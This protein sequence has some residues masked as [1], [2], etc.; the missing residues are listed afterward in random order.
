VSKRLSLVVLVAALLVVALAGGVLVALRSEL[1]GRRTG[2]PLACHGCGRSAT[3]A[4]ARVGEPVS[5]G[6]LTLRNESDATVTLERVALLDVDPGLE[7]IDNVVVQPDGRH[8][9]V[10]GVHGYPP[11]EP[12][13]TT[14]A[15]R[16]YKL[17]PA[18]SRADVVQVLFGLR[19][20]RPARAGARRIAVDYR[21]GRV[22]YRAYFDHSMWLCTWR[23]SEEG[24]CIDPDW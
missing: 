14:H 9:L 20:T 4:P 10:G 1:S 16:G 6:P 3:A 23:I 15:V 17:E 11:P 13:G 22:P 2:G 21:V 12:G 19:L 24:A 8:P 18:R 5:M 7:L